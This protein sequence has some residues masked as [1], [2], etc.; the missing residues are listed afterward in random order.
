MTLPYLMARPMTLGAH[1]PRQRKTSPRRQLRGL[2]RS[3]RGL[4]FLGKSSDVTPQQAFQQALSQFQQYNLNPRDTGNSAWVSD[5]I[6]QIQNGQFNTV[7]FSPACAGIIAANPDL[8]LTQA[9]GKIAGASTGAIAAAA[10]G[11]AAGTAL[12]VATLGI[13]V[14]VAV[15]SII[16][17]HHAAAV[18]QEQ[19]LGCTA[20]AAANNAMNV[21]A[22]GVSAGSIA[23]ADAATALNTVYSQFQALVKPSFSTS[24]YCSAD[25]EAQLC[26]LGMMIYWQ[27]QY[28]AMAD[29]QAATAAS[30]TAAA[31]QATA[32]G[33][34]VAAAADTA[35]AA[36]ASAGLPSWVLYAAG[37][38]LLYELVS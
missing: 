5:M 29:A 19:N 37:A 35:E 24:P 31:A 21:I 34:P 14:V 32:S 28:N 16:F 9:A 6:T 20:I 26:M 15:L 12:G 18:A 1:F 4:G 23:P 3:M 10:A 22:E 17:A 36:V 30:A 2:P 38:F 13:G 7:A 33:N 27:A 8:S 11:T 25:C